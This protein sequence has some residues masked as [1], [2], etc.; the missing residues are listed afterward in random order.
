MS[1]D[2]FCQVLSINLACKRSQAF[3]AGKELLTAIGCTLF[4]TPANM[5][6]RPDATME[7]A[8]SGDEMSD[9]EPLPDFPDNVC[10]LCEQEYGSP[11]KD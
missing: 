9:Q 10:P 2:L 6:E 5:A 1:N 8:A 3:D 7:A 11:D 4:A